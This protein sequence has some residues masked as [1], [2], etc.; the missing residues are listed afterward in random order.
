[1][2]LEE[3]ER[4]VDI[5]VSIAAG[6]ITV[7]VIGLWVVFHEE[8]KSDF[9][10]WRKHY[11]INCEHCYTRDYGPDDSCHWRCNR[12]AHMIVNEVNGYILETFKKSCR[13]TYGSRHCRWKRKKNE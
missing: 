12:T 9:M 6:M 5:T 3:K 2:S 10:K 8:V 7:I 1:M 4:L 11:C 13:E